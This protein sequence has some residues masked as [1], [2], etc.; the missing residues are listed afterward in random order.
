MVQHQLPSHDTLLLTRSY[1]QTDAGLELHIPPAPSLVPVIGN[2][3]APWA[4]YRLCK[5]EGFQQ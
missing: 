5:P 4:A 2:M 1:R 3:H